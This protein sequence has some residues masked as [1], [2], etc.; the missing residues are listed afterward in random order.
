MPLTAM[1]IVGF[2][3]PFL[4]KAPISP[5]GQ[6]VKNWRQDG[7]RASRFAG[8]VASNGCGASPLS[9]MPRRLCF[10]MPVVDATV[11]AQLFCAAMVS[12]GL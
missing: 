4:S 6:L 9:A 2:T 1:K 5:I 12:A 3:M 10:L 11:V 7:W 8:Y